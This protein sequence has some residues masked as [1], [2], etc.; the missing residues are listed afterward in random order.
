MIFD[1]RDTVIKLNKRRYILVILYITLMSILFFSGLLEEKLK[2]ILA[3]SFSLI[4]IIYNII[5]YHINFCYFSFRDDTEQLNFRWVSMRTFDNKKKA[6]NIKT[7]DFVGFKFEKLFFGYKQNLIL[8]IKTKKGIANYPPISISALSK[9][10]KD[11]LKQ[12][13]NQF[14]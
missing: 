6:I 4:Y 7:N 14:V 1:N 13:L 10:H 9:K 5:A 12:S 11:M 8:T 3:I 2:A